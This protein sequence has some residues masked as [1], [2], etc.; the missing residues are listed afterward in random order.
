[1]TIPT[2]TT[3]ASAG[4]EVRRDARDWVVGQ[5]DQRTISRLLK[6]AVV[7][8]PIAWISTRSADGIL[9]LAPHS[10]FMILADDPPVLG[11]VSSGIKDT[12]RN[13]RETGEFVINIPD[14]GLA[15]VMNLTS[16]AFPAGEDE[17]RWAGLTPER[18]G[19]IGVPRVAEAPVAFDLRFREERDFGTPEHPSI[20]VVGD[21]LRVRVHERVLDQ[22]HAT[23][24]VLPGELQAIARMGG[25]ATY[26]RTTDRFDLTRPDWEDLR[27][28]AERS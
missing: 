6:S 22:N 25:P 24:H 21:V 26:T 18:S 1:V 13:I 11:F 5:D 28:Q 20:L 3:T 12:L 16:A 2:P 17:F 15:A 19:S 23:T 14:E 9:N 7:P 27:N 4:S 10:Y 8:R